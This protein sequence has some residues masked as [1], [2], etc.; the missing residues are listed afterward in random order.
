MTTRS[1][2]FPA[3]GAAAIDVG[4][5]LLFVLIGRASHDENPVLGALTTSWPFLVGLALGWVLARGWRDP[6]DIAR[7][8]LPVWAFTVVVGMLLRAVS[9]QGVQPSFVV[10]T[11][12]VLAVFLFGWRLLTGLVLRRQS[13]RALTRT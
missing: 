4:F 3:L 10:V 13:R 9:G 12:I 11:C 8:A 2:R 6:L 5:V 7:T 1:Q